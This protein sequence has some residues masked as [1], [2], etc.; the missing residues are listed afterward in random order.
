MRTREVDGW[1]LTR[2]IGGW[3]LSPHWTFRKELN[4][5]GNLV[6]WA[7]DSRPGG[8][9]EPFG[10]LTAAVRAVT[11]DYYGSL[12]DRRAARKAM[13]PAVDECFICRS[14]AHVTADCGR[15]KATDKEHIAVAQAMVDEDAKTCQDR[16]TCVLGAGITIAG[17]RVIGAPF[18]GNLGSYEACKRAIKYLNENGFRAYWYDGVMD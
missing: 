10:T 16:G 11:D 8:M 9:R 5:Q 6:W 2:T 12:E 4:E 14:K 3:V 13:T 18:Q 15:T 17:R 1:T 7:R